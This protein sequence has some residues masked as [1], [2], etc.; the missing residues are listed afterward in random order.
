MSINIP[1][2]HIKKLRRIDVKYLAP[3][4]IASKNIRIQ[5]CMPPKFFQMHNFISNIALFLYYYMYSW[6][7]I[8]QA[9]NFDFI[10]FSFSYLILITALLSALFDK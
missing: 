9:D 4:Q 2:L 1:I 7:I 8:L 5:V 10:Y 3:N 6:H